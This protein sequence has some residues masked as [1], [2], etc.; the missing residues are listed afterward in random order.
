MFFSCN[1]M[2]HCGCSALH[3]VNPMEW[4]WGYSE[5]EITSSRKHDLMFWKSILKS[6]RRTIVLSSVGIF[7]NSVK[8]M[9][10]IHTNIHANIHTWISIYTSNNWITFLEQNNF[11]ECSFMFFCFVNCKVWASFVRVIF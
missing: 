9:I 3:G 1:S 4:I 8:V 5:L 2:P 10:N 7:F 6:P 11:N